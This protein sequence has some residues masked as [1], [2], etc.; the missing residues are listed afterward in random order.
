M[1]TTTKGRGYLKTTEETGI[2]IRGEN[3][4][5]MI[6]MAP[7]VKY[8]QDT[9]RTPTKEMTA[10]IQGIAII[11]EK[12]RAATSNFS[13]EDQENT[14]SHRMTCSTGHA[15]YT[16]HSSMEKECHGMQ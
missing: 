2:A 10:E 9:K 15:I 5:T 1:L 11:A 4:A 13:Q 16:M 6:S 3:L 8:L 12:T 14:I 7:I